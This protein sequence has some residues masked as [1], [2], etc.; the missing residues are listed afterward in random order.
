[1]D[2]RRLRLGE[3]L[4]GISGAGLVLVMFLPWYLT[5]G[6]FVEPPE[7]YQALTPGCVGDA[8]EEA[9]V[10]AWDAFA[11]VDVLLLVAG[12]AGVILWCV[13]AAYSTVGVPVG[14]SALTAIGGAVASLVLSLRLVFPPEGAER[15]FGV[16]PGLLACLGVTVGGVLAM[17]DEGFGLR[18]SL[19]VSATEPERAPEVV[20][21]PLPPSGESGSA[22]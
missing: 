9:P 14:T 6:S 11:A 3:W 8:C 12:L 20:A 13:T 19:D 18:P 21:T 2:L 15:L 16:W 4:A 17:R 7:G 10:S 5:P 22:R 1:M